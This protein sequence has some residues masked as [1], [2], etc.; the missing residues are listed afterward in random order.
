MHI[1]PR[2][3]DAVKV[4]GYL[5]LT[6]L[7]FTSI[8][9]AN[10][11]TF[12]YANF[13]VYGTRF[14]LVNPTDAPITVTDFWTPFGVGGPAIT[15]AP[16]S[17]EHFDAFPFAGGNVF[18]MEIP[19]G[20]EAF[21]EIKHQGLFMRIPDL[22][23]PVKVASFYALKSNLVNYASYVF[24]AAP[25][26]TTGKIVGSDDGVELGTVEFTIPKGGVAILEVP[27]G[28]TSACVTIGGGGF[29]YPGMEENPAYIFAFVTDRLSH[30]MIPVTRY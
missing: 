6:L 7:I 24:I 11:G 17:A 5:L 15:V 20:L 30:N 12:A 22:G 25:D 18:A 28:S 23:T 4:L 29:G 1:K 26:G 16:H 21:S 27:L 10:A 2:L 19:A 13:D 9:V 14:T 3:H 8:T